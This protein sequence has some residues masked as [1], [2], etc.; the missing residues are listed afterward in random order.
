MTIFFITK[1]EL[2]KLSFKKL[3]NVVANINIIQ[4]NEYCK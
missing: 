4:Q 3:S 1:Y 2:R